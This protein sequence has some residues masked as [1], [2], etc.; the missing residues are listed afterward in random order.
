MQFVGERGTQMKN[1]FLARLLIA[2]AMAGAFGVA[3]SATSAATMRTLAIAAPQQDAAR[4]SAQY[5]KWL[6]NQVHHELAMLPWLSV[7]DNLEYRIEGTTVTLQ[8]QVVRPSIKPDAENAVKHIEG[9]T[10]VV[11]NIEVLPPSPMDS[12]IRM[13]TFRAIYSEP[14]LQRYGPNPVSSIHIVVKNGNVTLVGVV[15]N[16]TDKNLAYM[17]A[18]GVPNV[19]SV[20]NNLQVVKG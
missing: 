4:N 2:G 20:T 17:R 7:F 18:N 8:G 12:Q 9:V 16:D 13:A 6:N 3:T 15:D 19:F 5:E 14:S 1:N 11:N 10:N